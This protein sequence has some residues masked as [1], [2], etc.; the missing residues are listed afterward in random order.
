VKKAELEGGKVGAKLENADHPARR[1]ERVVTGNSG[2]ESDTKALDLWP[3]GG[4]FREGFEEMGGSGCR[5]DSDRAVERGDGCIA[6]KGDRGASGRRR[7]VERER[8]E[9]EMKVERARRGE[10]QRKTRPE[11][12]KGAYRHHA[13]PD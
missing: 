5:I 13:I 6:V 12:R 8:T 11:G 7:R 10:G 1:L 4:V 2:G 9:R 3:E